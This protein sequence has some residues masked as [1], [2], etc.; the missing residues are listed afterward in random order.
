VKG[1]EACP[2]MRMKWGRSHM[3]SEWRA[4]SPETHASLPA[5]G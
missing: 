4:E 5:G 3:K 2:D 1:F